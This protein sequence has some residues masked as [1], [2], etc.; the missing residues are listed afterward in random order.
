M[1][2]SLL[3]LTLVLTACPLTLSDFSIDG[4]GT[5]DASADGGD[6][7]G[8][9]GGSPQDAC[10]PDV[11]N[12]LAW[13]PMSAPTDGAREKTAS[14]A[15]SDGRV[16]VWGGADG[17]GNALATGNL[18][19]ATNDSWKAIATSGAPS[20]RVFA[21]AVCVGMKAVVFGGGDTAS[22]VDYADGA[23]YNA[24]SDTWSSM[25]SPPKD[26]PGQRAPYA[27]SLSSTAFFVG[28]LLKNGMAAPG[29]GAFYDPGASSWTAPKGGAPQGIGLGVAT[30][31][32]IV[33]AFGGLAGPSD[34]NDLFTAT[35][36]WSKSNAAG[37][38]SARHGAFAA[39]DGNELFIWGGA[40]TAGPLQTGALLTPPNGP[41]KV[42]SSGSQ[43]P[44]ARAAVD[45]QTGWAFAVG[46]QKTMVLGGVLSTSGNAHDGAIYNASSDTWT[47]VPSWTSNSDHVGGV[48]AWTGAQIIVWGG[49]TG[50]TLT[51]TGDR[52]TL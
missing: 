11:C 29:T 33:F 37:G 10:P 7:G 2:R 31:P 49:R 50:S 43:A 28:G 46:A 30:S 15:F 8:G 42:M 16:F 17:A 38:P 9:D 44:S 52:W 27:G 35:S 23:T 40:S 5:F 4:G 32:S 14:C 18:Y 20:A 19:D 41:W 51:A 21:T 6:D 39:F 26:L 12:A 22:T 3:A 1:R 48:A 13:T 47:A 45:A 24:T 36:M 25:P 34:N